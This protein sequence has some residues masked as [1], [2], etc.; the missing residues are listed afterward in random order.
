MAG[1]KEVV[2]RY[3]AAYNRRDFA[4]YEQLFSPDFEGW[5]AGGATKRGVEGL[6]KIDQGFAAAFPDS[7]I[8]SLRKSADGCG[9]HKLSHAARRVYSWS[10]PPRRSRR[11][12]GPPGAT[13][14]PPIIGGCRC[15]ARCGRA[16]L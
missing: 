6:R 13:G 15:S 5:A 4:A 14:S 8:V 12:T 9:I 2:D 3:Y 16:W 1:A 7:Q 11:T 10:T